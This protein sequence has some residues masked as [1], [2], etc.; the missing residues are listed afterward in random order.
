MTARRSAPLA[1][2]FPAGVVVFVADLREPVPLLEPVESAAL[3]RAVPE[4][5]AEFARGRACAR[6][7][8]ADLG[9]DPV[10]IPMGPDRAPIWPGGS[11]GSITHCAG[12]IAAAVG[13]AERFSGIG[14][15]AEPRGALEAGLADR[16]ATAP[17]RAAA[18]ID[19]LVPGP[20]LPRLIFSAKE[21]V[22]KCAHPVSRITL[23]FLDVAIVFDHRRRAFRVEPASELARS[24]PALTQIEGR[25]WFDATH[26]VTAGCLLRV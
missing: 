4:R 9:F 6:A 13:R 23:D 26:L 7:G 17:E 20:E 21:V 19:G 18:G 24:I 5:R 1:A 25:Y 8:L 12:M 15:D 3:S 14:L 22:H 10:A 11:I 16:I 2:L